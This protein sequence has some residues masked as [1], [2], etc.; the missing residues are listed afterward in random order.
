[1]ATNQDTKLANMKT[2]LGVTDGHIQ[3]LEKAWLLSKLSLSSSSL[4]IATLWGQVFDAESVP[5]GQFNDRMFYYLQTTQGL[6]GNTIEDLMSSY[7]WSLFTPASLDNLEAWYQFNTGITVTGA[8]VSQWDDQSGNDRHLLQGTDTNRPAKE[9]GGEI[10]FDGV[11]NFLKV[12]SFTINQPLTIVVLFKQVTWTSTDYIWEFGNGTNAI[13]L[14][15]YYS[16]GEASPDIRMYS[17]A[18]GPEY[19]SMTLD[20]YFSVACV[21]NGASSSLSMDG[22]SVDT[23]DVGATN[24]TLFTLGANGPATNYWT[25]MQVKDIVITSDALSAADISN[26]ASYHASL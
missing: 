19:R 2:A 21:Y 22:S 20:T 24:G 18:N 15:Q 6:T 14:Q 10:T 16:V 11:D 5:A 12:A 13:V 3:D 17:G 25:N 26:I 7:D 1:M 8:G 9:T 23:A 4:D